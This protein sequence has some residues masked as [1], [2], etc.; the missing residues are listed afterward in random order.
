MED[1]FEDYW[2][3]I[4]PAPRPSMEELRETPQDRR[5]DRA[6]PPGPPMGPSMGCAVGAARSDH[7]H[8]GPE[9]RFGVP[10]EFLSGGGPLLMSSGS[11]V[12]ASWIENH[13]NLSTNEEFTRLQRDVRTLSEVVTSLVA[14]VGRLEIENSELRTVLN[15]L[16]AMSLNVSPS[17]RGFLP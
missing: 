1:D 10:E 2:T 17:R 9:M 15:S 12:N 6:A 11:G 4:R 3:A 16:Q 5:G 13:L 7:V 8:S 14:Q